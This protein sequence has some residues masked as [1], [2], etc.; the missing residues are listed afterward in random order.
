MWTGPRC[1]QGVLC[2]LK[3]ESL[4]LLFHMVSMVRCARPETGGE[5]TDGYRREQPCYRT[6]SGRC[7]EGSIQVDSGADLGRRLSGELV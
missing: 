3:E 4:R 1:S 6:D 5:G 2:E 7:V